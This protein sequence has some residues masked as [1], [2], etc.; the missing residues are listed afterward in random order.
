MTG[1]DLLQP[2]TRVRPNNIQN[3]E[4]DSRVANVSKAKLRGRPGYPLAGRDFV[5]GG[6]DASPRNSGSRRRYQ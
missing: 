5:R 3:I 4:Y 2:N 1:Y 6:G